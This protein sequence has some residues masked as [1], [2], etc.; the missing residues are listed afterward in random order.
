[1][2]YRKKRH[3]LSNYIRVTE[4]KLRYLRRHHNTMQSPYNELPSEED[5]QESDAQP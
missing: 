3:K 2:Y 5:H 4:P 1:M